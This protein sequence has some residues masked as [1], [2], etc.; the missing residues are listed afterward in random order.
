MP[1][2]VPA[3]VMVPD[4]EHYLPFEVTYGKVN[5][6]EKIVRHWKNLELPLKRK[7]QIL[8]IFQIELWHLFNATNAVKLDVCI[9]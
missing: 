5:T 7:S 9:A 4:R 3:P 6:T 8:N 2:K 1:P